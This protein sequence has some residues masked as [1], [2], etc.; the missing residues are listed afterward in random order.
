VPDRNSLPTYEISG[1]IDRDDLPERKAA[2]IMHA[3]CLTGDPEHLQADYASDRKV[4][5]GVSFWSG[6]FTC[7]QP[8]QSLGATPPG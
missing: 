5:D 6:L 2:R 7:N 8:I 1:H 4:S 3:T